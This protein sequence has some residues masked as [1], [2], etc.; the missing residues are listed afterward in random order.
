MFTIDPIKKL[1]VL[2]TVKDRIAQVRR[3]ILDEKAT[4]GTKHT[5][6]WG[7]TLSQQL[8]ILRI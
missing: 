7:T 4:V 3:I 6:E 8:S 2:E 5:F 1:E